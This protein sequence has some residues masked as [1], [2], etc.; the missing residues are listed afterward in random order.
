MSKMQRNDNMQHRK[1]QGIPDYNYRYPWFVKFYAEMDNTTL[2]T[3]F[4]QKQEKIRLYREYIRG[5][6]VRSR[7][8][9][10]FVQD[11]IET[12]Q[13]QALSIWQ[14]IVARKRAGRD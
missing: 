4:S 14:L 8:A 3:L 7:D 6:V 12:M 1:I 2:E 9:I 13:R 5:G 10:K 11:E